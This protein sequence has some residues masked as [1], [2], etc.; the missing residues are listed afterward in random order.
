[1]TNLK[2]L[3]SQITST[4]PFKKNARISSLDEIK[5]KL[6][7][8]VITPESALGRMWSVFE[9]ELRL[10]QENSLHRQT[11]RLHGE[12]VLVTV[13]KVGM[14][15]MYF[16]TVDN[17]VGYISKDIDGKYIFIEEK[18]K[19]RKE[20]ILTYVDGLQKQIRMGYYALP[21]AYKQKIQETK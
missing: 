3:K 19:K 18:E 6:E 1:M 21:L 2:R 16:H 8:K 11:I 4:I 14:M 17:R 5:S 9:D 7:E 12:E 20:M 10:T 13:A 15:T